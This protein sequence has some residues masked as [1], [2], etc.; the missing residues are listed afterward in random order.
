MCRLEAEAGSMT[1]SLRAS[2]AY[3]AVSGKGLHSIVHQKKKIP[4]AGLGCFFVKQTSLTKSI[5]GKRCL[6]QP[7]G[8]IKVP[9]WLGTR[10]SQAKLERLNLPT[11]TSARVF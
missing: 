6:L 3:W 5:F 11:F 8:S 1:L 9:Q 2:T 4:S 10:K 7:Y